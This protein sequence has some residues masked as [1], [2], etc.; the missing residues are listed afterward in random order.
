MSA[1]SRRCLHRAAGARESR[2]MRAKLLDQRMAMAKLG[3][4][5]FPDLREI[6]A[7][8]RQIQHRTIGE[9][10]T[11]LGETAIGNDALERGVGNR[12]LQRSAELV[13]QHGHAAQTRDAAWRWHSAHP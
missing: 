5:A 6:L 2:E 12:L 7:H 4:F 8:G 1:C 3:G 13:K 11:N 9:T 10:R